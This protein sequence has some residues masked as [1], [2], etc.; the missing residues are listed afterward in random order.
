MHERERVGKVSYRIS[1]FLY[2]DPSE[3]QG[4]SSKKVR[5][6]WDG[7][8]GEVKRPGCVK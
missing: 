7:R 3:Q 4:R 2:M 6:P 1:L 5:A 8:S